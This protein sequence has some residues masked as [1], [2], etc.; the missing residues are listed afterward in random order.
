MCRQ[1]TLQKTLHFFLTK[2]IIGITVVGGLV[3]F[4][5]W[6]GRLLLEKTLLTDDSKNVIIA[7]SDAAIALLSY[8]FLF[9]VY[10]KRRIKELSLSTF[11]K[12][13]I[14]G[15][16]TGLILQS[17]FILVIYIAG[18]YSV[19]RINPVS[20]LLPSFATAFTAGFVAEVLIR[21]IFFRLTEEKSGTVIALIISALLFAVLHSGAKGATLL[22]VLSTTIQAGILLTAAYVFTRS[23][24]FPI[25]LHFAWD[26]AEPGIKLVLSS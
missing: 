11:G 3:V 26:F 9:R 23:L 24:W 5:E 14:I 21:G 20:F 13:A 2:I 12:N 10:E 4:M 15:F 8:I 16:A 25:F 17:L 19:I 1:I 7:I 22:S 6:S 18:S